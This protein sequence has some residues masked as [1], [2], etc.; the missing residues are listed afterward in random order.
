MCLS[1]L[2]GDT[3][4]S[5]DAGQWACAANKCVYLRS[6]LVKL[7]QRALRV[8]SFRSR[9]RLCF[10]RSLAGGTRRNFSRGAFRT[11]RE[12]QPETQQMCQPQT[13]IRG[14][15]VSVP[16][17]SVPPVSLFALSLS[18]LSLAWLLAWLLHAMMIAGKTETRG[19][20]QVI[21]RK[22]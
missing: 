11:I 6:S 12:V 14:R 20:K 16:C 22:A 13:Q 21:K 5:D 1:F 18:R 9:F 2:T 17:N 8:Q 7:K 3:R 15:Q 10:V 19:N 4:T